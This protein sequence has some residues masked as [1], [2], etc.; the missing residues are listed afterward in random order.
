[1]YFRNKYFYGLD[2]SHESFVEYVYE[3]KIELDFW[4]SNWYNELWITYVR[5]LESICLKKNI[6]EISLN[7][8]G[9]TSI[10]VLVLYGTD[11]SVTLL[12]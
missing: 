6:F 2:F 12:W 10:T 7:G 9:T 1:M 11:S 4:K 5:S 8:Y 3:K